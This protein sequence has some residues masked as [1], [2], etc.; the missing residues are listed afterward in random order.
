MK[1]FTVEIAEWKA[2]IK[3][4]LAKHKTKIADDDEKELTCEQVCLLDLSIDDEA[5]LDSI[6]KSKLDSQE[7]H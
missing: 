5:C 4:L 3:P 6:I 2:E 7:D 1:L